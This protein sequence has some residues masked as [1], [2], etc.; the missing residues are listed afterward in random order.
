[1]ELLRGDAHFAA[2]AELSAVG[3]AGGGVDVYGGAVHAA[4]EAVCGC[5]IG[6][7]NGLAVTCG[8]GS[9][10]LN[11]FFHRADDL[12]GQNVVQKFRVEIRGACGG[13]A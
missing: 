3:K 7:Q 4:D 8:V 1:M 10:V 5:L 9:D 11:R 6:G 12:D 13:A 2:Q